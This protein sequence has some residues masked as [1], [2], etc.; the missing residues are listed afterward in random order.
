M[1]VRE[2]K[3]FALLIL[4]VP[5]LFYLLLSTLLLGATLL[6]YDIDDS[7]RIIDRKVVKEI[8]VPADGFWSYRLSTSIVGTTGTT[9]ASDMTI[10]GRG[11]ADSVRTPLTHAT[12]VELDVDAAAAP[13]LLKSFESCLDCSPHF[14]LGLNNTSNREVVVT[15]SV[16][17][18]D[19]FETQG[20]ASFRVTCVN[21][22]CT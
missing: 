12:R 19:T 5:C 16:S 2:I 1:G 20:G 22:D 13:T 14:L 4:G 21:H 10:H 7:P 17:I 3:V 8:V 6:G 15:V 18:F 9:S 11:T